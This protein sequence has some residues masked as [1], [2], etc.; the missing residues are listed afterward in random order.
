MGAR[1]HA[2]NDPG[3][4]AVIAES[5]RASSLGDWLAI[6]LP[7][8]ERHLGHEHSSIML[9]L[10]ETSGPGRRAFAGTVHG[11]DPDVLDEYFGRWAEL[12]PLAGELAHAAFVACGVVSTAD[13]YP[14]L[15]RGRRRF[16]DEFLRPAGIQDQLSLKLA[17]I[18]TDG[19]LTIHERAEFSEAQRTLL[20]GLVPRLT[21]QLRSY[22][23][24]GL[25]TSLSTRESH[26]A[27][28]VALGFG[29]GEIAAVLGVAEDTVKKHIYRAMTKLGMH[30][31]SQL[32]VAWMTGRMLV[33]PVQQTAP[34]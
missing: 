16:V 2:V 22:L 18:G 29:N 25:P 30:R 21:R 7:A 3:V 11:E 23:P 20:E 13:L 8:I 14:Q 5:A 33:L 10:S 1:Q 31:R 15:D 19:Y 4:Q 24:R 28:L 9:V 17:G 6:T 32:A 26:V 27:E 34:T 12:D